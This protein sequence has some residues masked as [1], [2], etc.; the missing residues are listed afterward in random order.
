MELR[1]DRLGKE[2][3]RV[4]VRYALLLGS[5]ALLVLSG[6]SA[7]QAASRAPA[8]SVETD[9]DLQKKE[10]EKETKSV[11]LRGDDERLRPESQIQRMIGDTLFTFTGA[12]D[13]DFNYQKNLNLDD[14]EERDRFRFTPDLRFN[15]IFEFPRGFYLFSEFKLED[16]LAL[17]EQD[18]PM[19]FFEFQLNEFFLQT[20]LPLPLP[21]ALRI[22]RQ[23]FFEPRRWFLDEKLDG[24]RLLIDPNPWHFRASVSAPIPEPT[25]D[26]HI[27]IFDDIDQSRK[28]IDGLIYASVDIL[29]LKQKSKAGF[30][31]LVRED[32][33]SRDEDPIWV[34]IRT[35]GRPRFKFNLSD[36]EL[37]KDF[38]KPRI[39]YWLDAAFVAGTVRSQTIRG[40][41]IDLGASYIARKLPYKPYVTIGYAYGSGDS[42]P[43]NGKDRNFR[44][45][46]FQGNSGKYGGVVNFPYYG[47][48][49]DPELSNIHIYTAGLGFRPLPRT[50]VDIVYHHYTQASRSDDLREIDVN[51]DLNGIHKNLGNEIDVVV[52]FRQIRNI[53]VR[54]RN[55]YFFPG[56]AFAQR[57]SAF[58]TRLDIQI[59]F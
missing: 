11:A 26:D 14:S 24:I 1:T 55:G 8:P 29:P 37:I 45:T 28:Q 9:P 40:Y 18:K 27:R 21:S 35:F 5:L 41:G 59:G 44:Q 49:L 43:K 22:G 13:L 30:Y 2:R 47:V 58:E 23:Q 38:L 32:T 56:P 51:E 36:N 39:K 25:N 34:G 6:P 50:S 3:K 16:E 17:R 15:L 12:L 7:S 4:F 48:L 42:N 10:L 19:N 20:P 53:R 31:L 46:G 54:W 33:S 52:G 57:D